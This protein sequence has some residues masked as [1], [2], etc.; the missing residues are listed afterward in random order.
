M[1]K[2]YGLQGLIINMQQHDQTVTRHNQ[3]KAL[4]VNHLVHQ[5]YPVSDS[6]FYVLDANV[7]RHMV[8]KPKVNQGKLN[9]LC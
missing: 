1:P 9:A 3:A 5:L 6:W 8:H 4:C 7:D 2:W